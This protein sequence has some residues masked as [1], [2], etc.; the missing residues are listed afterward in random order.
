MAIRF[1]ISAILVLLTGPVLAAAPA[2]TPTPAE[3][4]VAAVLLIAGAT[5]ALA[6]NRDC[7]DTANTQA[8][9]TRCSSQ[10]LQAANRKMAAAY[11]AVMCHLEGTDK[12]ALAASQRAF[13][14]FGKADCS[15]WGGGVGGG[16]MSVM[17]ENLCRADLANKRAAELDTW[18]PNSPRDALVACH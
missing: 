4:N 16:S 2:N 9:L 12:K 13:E 7:M 14:A 1:G 15:F 17:N 18:P 6:Q 8:G 5:Q 11:N 3:A 10:K